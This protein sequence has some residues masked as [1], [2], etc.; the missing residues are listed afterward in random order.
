MARR[1]G[2]LATVRINAAGLAPLVRGVGGAGQRFLERKAA[3]VAVLARANSVSNGSISQ[4]IVVGPVEGNKIKV[5]STNIHTLLVHNG[6]RPHPIFPRRSRGRRGGT[7]Y[8]RFV[9]DGRVVYARKVNHPG[10][11]GNPF[12]TDALKQAR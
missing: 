2:R 6:S 3:R 1:G 10:Y 8:L 4:G 7:P 12:L 11:K 9:V 5:I